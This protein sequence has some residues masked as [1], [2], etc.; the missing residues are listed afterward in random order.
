MF[1]SFHLDNTRSIY[2]VS[3]MATHEDEDL[4]L[5]LCLQAKTDDGNSMPTSVWLSFFTGYNFVSLAN[6]AGYDGKYFWYVSSETGGGEA[7]DVVLHV[8]KVQCVM[9]KKFSPFCPSPAALILEGRAR[10]WLVRHFEIPTRTRRGSPGP[11]LID[12]L[13]HLGLSGG[14]G[15]LPHVLSPR[16]L[17]RLLV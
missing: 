3:L 1:E 2:D 9:K 5:T 8:N 17:E 6:S 7:D 12:S 10:M 16:Q 11:C 4:F 14:S 13:S 15:G